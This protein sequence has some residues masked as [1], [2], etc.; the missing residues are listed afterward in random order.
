MTL[1]T[2]LPCWGAE[3]LAVDVVTG[4]RDE[5]QQRA[6]HDARACD[7]GSVT[8]RKVVKPLA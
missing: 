8:V 1:P 7:S 2:I 5:G 6:G 4:R 3:Q